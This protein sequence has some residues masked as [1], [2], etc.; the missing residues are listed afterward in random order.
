M[1]RLDSVI[2]QARDRAVPLVAV[3]ELAERHRA[4][5][6]DLIETAEAIMEFPHVA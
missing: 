4:R 3:D 5:V 2:R 1:S 6:L